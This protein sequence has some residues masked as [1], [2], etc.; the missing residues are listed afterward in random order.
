MIVSVDEVEINPLNLMIRLADMIE[1]Y[2][3]ADKE[4]LDLFP[5][6]YARGMADSAALILNLIENNE[7]K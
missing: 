2:R 5:P 1:K 7:F 4:K 6:N 3:E